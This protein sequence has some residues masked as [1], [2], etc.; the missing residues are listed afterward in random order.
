VSET[1][2]EAGAEDRSVGKSVLEADSEAED[3]AGDAL[4]DTVDLDEKPEEEE[5]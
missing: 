3:L 5:E 1:E 2:E 4:D